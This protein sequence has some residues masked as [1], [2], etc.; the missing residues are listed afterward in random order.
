MEIE[1]DAI[2]PDAI[3]AEARERL[4]RP[5]SAA[6]LLTALRRVQ[7]MLVLDL[8]RCVD[9]LGLSY[10]RVEVMELLDARPTIHGGEIA[11]RLRI[12]R[13]AA[14][15]LLKHLELGDLAERRPF[16][17]FVRP[18]ALTDAGRARLRLA[19]SALEGA[20]VTLERLSPEERS[21][22]AR[23]L[24]ALERALVPRVERWW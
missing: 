13:Q 6:A 1:L 7:H 3:I 22:L 20:H 19:R 9:D 4:A 5:P 23:G 21:A 14:H 15:R 24:G 11:R 8:D 12:T 2:D 10:A 16:D 18:A 17:G